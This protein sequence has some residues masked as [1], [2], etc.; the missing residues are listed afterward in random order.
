MTDAV[1]RLQ[2]ANAPVL[3]AGGGEIPLPA[4]NALLLAWLAIEGPTPRARLAQ[5]LWPDSAP[6]AARNAL[7]QRLFQLKK[8][9]G[10]DL[11]AGQEVLSLAD[12]V[13]HDLETSDDMLAGLD[14]EAGAE[15]LE[16]LARQRQRRRERLRQS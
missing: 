15:L 7:R 3:C 2:L 8:L 9:T 1:A 10:I 16:W 5:L 4:R 6:Q 13:L 14:I 11:V 12:G